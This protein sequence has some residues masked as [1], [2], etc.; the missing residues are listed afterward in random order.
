[1]KQGH[2]RE[3]GEILT[4]CN[5]AFYGKPKKKEVNMC[6]NMCEC[7]ECVFPSLISALSPF[8]MHVANGPCVTNS[9]AE[10]KWVGEERLHVTSPLPIVR[11]TQRRVLRRQACMSARV[12]TCWFVWKVVCPHMN[13]EHVM[14]ANRPSGQQP[15]QGQSSIRREANV[16]RHGAWT[17]C[18]R[19]QEGNGKRKIWT[20]GKEAWD[21]N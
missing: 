5:M 17:V 14:C 19:W 4:L 11:S 10:R 12:L 7:D 6:P 20:V 18:V 21:S 15:T 16:R 9:P 3:R 13:C 8:K 1:M 2:K